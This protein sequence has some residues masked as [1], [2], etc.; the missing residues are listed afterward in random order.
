M[1]FLEPSILLSG[2][3]HTVLFCLHWVALQSLTASQLCRSSD[4]QLQYLL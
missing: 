1:E 3:Y 4:F 2:E